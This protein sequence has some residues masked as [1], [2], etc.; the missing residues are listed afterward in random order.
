M[1]RITILL[2]ILVQNVF[3]QKL[4]LF[5]P[6]L[7][8]G[9]PNVRDFTMSKKGNE[10]YFTVE[11]FAKEYSFIAFSKKKNDLW[12]APKVASFSGKYKDLEPF[13]SPD[14]LKLFFVSNRTNN[15]SSVIKEDTD[16]WYV[17]RN[18][19]I[20]K[21][22]KPKSI[23]IKINTL[24]DEFY[25]SVTNKGDLFF[26]AN[27][28]D[29]KGKEDIYVSRLINNKYTKPKS[30]SKKI[31][32]DKYE[33]NAYVSPDESFIIYTSYGRK[34]DL[35]KGDLYINKK[36]ANN[37][38]L[39]PEHINKGVN[40]PE[41]D[42]CPFVDTV[43]NTLYFTTRKSLITKSFKKKKT[44][45]EIIN[46]INTNPNGLSRIYRVSLNKK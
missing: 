28:K 3:S 44:M 1:K 21:W 8:N 41:L 27:Y 35:G 18:K 10:F 25:P 6:E 20:D 23:G 33:F 45:K 31:N 4:E 19:I 36:D 7:F 5:S 38:W 43:N 34:D 26:T 42:Y 17:T 16:I 37:N 29:S 32:S 40:T 30:L 14:G 24:R 46:Y 9:L 2:L 11:S 13:L 15:T 12:S 39:P 22:S